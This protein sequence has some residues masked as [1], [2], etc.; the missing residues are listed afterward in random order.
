MNFKI[1]VYFMP[2]LILSAIIGGILGLLTL[3]PIINLFAFLAYGLVGGLTV[4]LLKRK[5]LVGIL[6]I[7]DGTIIGAISGFVAV[8][9]A[10]I[11]YM[12]IAFILGQFLAAFSI[13]FKMNVPFWVASLNIFFTFMIVSFLGFLN[14]LFS[15]F[16]GLIAAFIYE[17]IESQTEQDRAEFRIDITDN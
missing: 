12:P 10:S 13:G 15:A 17:K 9:A 11:V 8:I 3:I 14:A 4:Y 5:A 16:S 2:T 7:N 1:S 6:S